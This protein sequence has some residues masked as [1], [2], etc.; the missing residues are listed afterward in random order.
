VTRISALRLLTLILLVAIAAG[1]GGGGGDDER[2]LAESDLPQLVLRPADLTKDWTQFDG[3]RQLSSDAP[4]GERADE[5]RFDRQG[6]WKARYRRS[7]TPA[8]QGPLVVVSLA[9]LFAGAS[10]AEQDFDAA[11][12]ALERDA[13]SSQPVEDLDEL[14][15]DA[16]LLATGSSGP[17]ELATVTIVWREQNVVAVVTA[18]GFSGRLAP[19]DAIEL[20]QKQQKRLESALN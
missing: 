18:N 19:D 2:L 16:R 3:G 4:S 10:G 8:T 15:D 20:A 11:V 6:G 13:T 1:C 17:E 7:G 9:D 12:D 5:T 14:G